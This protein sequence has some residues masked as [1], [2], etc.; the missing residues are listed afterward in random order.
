MAGLGEHDEAEDA[1]ERAPGLDH[2]RAR[3]DRG[4]RERDGRESVD[5]IGCPA[6]IN[7]GELGASGARCT[8]SSALVLC[9]R[10]STYHL[11]QQRASAR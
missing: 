5:E 3:G 1:S 7:H 11:R 6:S 2:A 10:W 4:G 9:R 8:A